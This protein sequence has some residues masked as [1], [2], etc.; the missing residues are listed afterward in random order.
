MGDSA[1]LKGLQCSWIGRNGI[2]F[3][4]KPSWLK[5]LNFKCFYNSYLHITMAKSLTNQLTGWFT[6]VHTSEGNSAQHDR[7]GMV[8]ESVLI[9][10]ITNTACTSCLLFTSYK[11][12]SVKACVYHSTGSENILTHTKIRNKLKH[13]GQKV[14]YQTGASEWLGLTIRKVI[15]GGCLRQL[16]GTS[17]YQKEG[18]LGKKQ[19]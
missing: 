9:N 8:V 1:S 19:S 17:S 2:T 16:P 3:L 12:S 6:L 11:Q 7:K 13:I 10:S 14:S 15:C 18:Q 4:M 5:K